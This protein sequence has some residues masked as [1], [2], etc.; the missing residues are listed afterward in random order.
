MRPA[1]IFS[2]VILSIQLLLIGGQN[3]TQQQG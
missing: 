2:T 1:V 3:D